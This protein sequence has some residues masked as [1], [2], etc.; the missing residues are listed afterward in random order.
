[1]VPWYSEET[2]DRLR[3]LLDVYRR[4]AGLSLD[5]LAANLGAANAGPSASTLGR[6]VSASHGA[7][8]SE[9]SMRH[10]REILQHLSHLL[11]V[12]TPNA[13]MFRRAC[14]EELAFFGLDGEYD[15]SA[16]ART[17]RSPSAE[18]QSM[19]AQICGSYLIARA[20]ERGQFI[21]SLA[22]IDDAPSRN[23]V[24]R[25]IIHRIVQTARSVQMS[26][27]VSV[28]NSLLYL[29]GVNPLNQTVRFLCFDACDLERETFIGFLTG[30]ESPGVSFSS[31]C[32]MVRLKPDT[33]VE[34]Q[35]LSL[36][37]LNSGPAAAERLRETVLNAES[38]VAL[39][40]AFESGAYARIDPAYV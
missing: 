7:P 2:M 21:F 31:K 18:D 32:L 11:T 28:M 13:E 24:N 40:S 27:E 5:A 6:F 26:C 35:I 14:A 20:F 9:L 38:A 4:H 29:R 17:T 22:E 25:C 10:V 33:D 1:M 16:A 37:E 19:L 12:Y 23:G 30:F 8:G 34:A 39:L 3:R 15:S 36:R